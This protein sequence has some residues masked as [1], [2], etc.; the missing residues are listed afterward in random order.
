[1]CTKLNAKYFIAKR[2]K[3]RRYLSCSPLSYFVFI[4]LS[5][6]F[7]LHLIPLYFIF[8]FCLW[9]NFLIGK[10][11]TTHNFRSCSIKINFFAIFIL[12]IWPLEMKHLK[13]TYYIYIYI[14]KYIN[15]N[16]DF[17]LHPSTRK[18]FLGELC[19]DVER[20]LMSEEMCYYMHQWN[21]S[22]FVLRFLWD[23]IRN[24]GFIHAFQ[25]CKLLTAIMFSKD[26]LNQNCFYGFYIWKQAL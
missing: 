3:S 5:D 14:Y 16:I 17:S 6:V 10:I 25:K 8:I 9:L 18:Y 24:A 23:W 11:F 7:Y 20:H 26:F 4:L 21:L 15:S 13:Y 12:R 22:S 1:M 19:I 2:S